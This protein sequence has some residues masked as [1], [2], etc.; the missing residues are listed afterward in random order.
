MKSWWPRW[1]VWIFFLLVVVATAIIVIPR[2]KAAGIDQYDC[3]DYGSTLAE[4]R[5]DLVETF[6]PAMGHSNP[7]VCGIAQSQVTETKTAFETALLI[8]TEKK[9]KAA[10]Y[11]ARD[12]VM[13]GLS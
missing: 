11:L 13:G 12:Q 8:D 9:T 5:T 4:F 3:G 7:G 10:Q 6:D 2:A 1:K